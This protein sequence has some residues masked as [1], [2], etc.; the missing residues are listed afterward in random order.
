MISKVVI[1]AA[2][3]IMLPFVLLAGVILW[4]AR[5]AGLGRIP[6]SR[7]A[8]LYIGILPVR[9]HYYEPFF[10]A[11]ELRQ[12]LSDER[13]LPGIDWNLD[14]QLALLKDLRYAD[15][16]ADLARPPPAG[17]AAGT[18]FHFNNGAFESGD[19]EFLYQIVRARKPRRIIEVGS[20]NSTL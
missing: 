19:A 1:A 20:G 6:L 2:D 5:R 8:L 12:P 14:E 18:Q 16:L 15:E 17:G 11:R 4:M 9:R 3:V 13:H 10:S 7:S